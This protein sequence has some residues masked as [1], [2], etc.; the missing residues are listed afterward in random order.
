MRIIIVASSPY[1]TFDKYIYNENDFLIGIEDG[2]YDII[3]K[4]FK[5]QYAVGDFDTTSHL[6]KIKKSA[7]EIDIYSPIK[8]EIDLELALKY[9]IKNNLQGEIL[10]YNACMGRMDHELITIKLLIKY[11][12][13]P[14]TLISEKEE[15]RYINKDYILSKGAHRF[16]LIPIKDVCLEIIN[17]KYPL[18][19][20]NLTILD[21]YTSSNKTHDTLDTKIKIYS[22]GVILIKE[23]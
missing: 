12:Q 9:I 19:K 16:S 8:D 18:P 1:K 10:I 23:S 13:L 20:T 11:D 14:I 15:I 17:A 21:N 22:G 5:L 3:E 6:E 4:G 2:A 7:L